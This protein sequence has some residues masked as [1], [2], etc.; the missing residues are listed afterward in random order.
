MQD[1][2]CRNYNGGMLDKITWRGRHLSILTGKKWDSFKNDGGMKNRKL[3]V[4][5]SY[6]MSGW[7]NH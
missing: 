1:A 7:C 3:D 6:K 4:L 5:S 2:G